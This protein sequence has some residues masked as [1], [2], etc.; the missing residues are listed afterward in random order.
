MQA[1]GC[2]ERLGSALAVFFHPPFTSA[3]AADRTPSMIP[4]L[5]GHCML[6]LPPLFQGS[7][8]GSWWKTNSIAYAVHLKRPAPLQTAADGTEWR[9]PVPVLPLLCMHLHITCCAGSQ[10]VAAVS[11]SPCRGLSGQQ[12]EQERTPACPTWPLQQ[13]TSAKESS[14]RD[15]LSGVSHRRAPRRGS[16]AADWEDRGDT[17]GV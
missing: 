11:M 12:T 5:A 16:A 15:A 8:C 1:D 3:Q 10:R 6:M 7:C 13:L 9:V 4:V 14:G 2:I 17:A